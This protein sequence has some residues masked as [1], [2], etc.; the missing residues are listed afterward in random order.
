[1]TGPHFNVTGMG[2]WQTLYWNEGPKAAAN[3]CDQIVSKLTTILNN[4]IYPLWRGQY[5]TPHFSDC[6]TL[7]QGYELKVT[8]YKPDECCLGSLFS[9]GRSEPG[10]TPLNYPD[11]RHKYDSMESLKEHFDRK[12]KLHQEM[13]TAIENLL[14]NLPAEIPQRQSLELLKEDQARALKKWQGRK[15]SEVQF[16]SWLL[17]PKKNPLQTTSIDWAHQNGYYG[18]NGK[19]IVLESTNADVTHPFL[20]DSFCSASI[21]IP[22]EAHATHVSGIIAAKKD[23]VNG[24][25]GAAPCSKI[26]L[27]YG[28]NASALKIIQ[29][30]PIPFVNFSG[31]FTN[32]FAELVVNFDQ[33][34][35]F[36]TMLEEMRQSSPSNKDLVQLL[37]L[38]REGKDNEA[39]NMLQQLYQDTT[40][41]NRQ[42]FSSAFEKKLVIAAI[43]NDGVILRESS[44]CR[45]AFSSWSKI[46]ADLGIYVVNLHSD[47]LTH[48]KSS[49]LPGFKYGDCTI[50]AVGHEVL[51]CLPGGNYGKQTGTSM[52]A[53]F[54]SSVAVLLKSAFP[55]L[56]NDQIRKC[57]LDSATPIVLDETAT[58]HLIENTADLSHYTQ[59]QI[60]FSKQFFGK[61]LLNAKGAFEI[62][63]SLVYRS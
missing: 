42:A 17:P 23:E 62:A 20:A 9:V 10:R 25:S 32:I 13:L 63:R 34:L 21:A 51:S 36:C 29:E 27:V 58:P 59:E 56:N 22:S 57:I 38:K 37:Q 16:P 31:D 26:Q 41:A 15:E 48:S 12:I 14:Q 1:M 11:F 43:G 3:Y 44:R 49:N 30:S 46:V 8:H 39:R 35:L 61:G 2:K 7:R 60:N 28:S 33:H 54:V 24:H 50:S 40:N 19:I 47:G 55:Q 4:T 18:E 53:P 45:S 5:N 52:A 6:N